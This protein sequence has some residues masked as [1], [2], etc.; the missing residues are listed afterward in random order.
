MVGVAGSVAVNQ[1]AGNA[2]CRGYA[3]MPLRSWRPNH[4]ADDATC[5]GADVA[6][7]DYFRVTIPS[8]P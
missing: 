6:G 4:A 7:T 5:P 1:A 2:R 8:E 3:T